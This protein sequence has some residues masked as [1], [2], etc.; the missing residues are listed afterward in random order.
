MQ[1]GVPAKDVFTCAYGETGEA[2]EG[3]AHGR[4]GAIPGPEREQLRL[5][6][7]A[8]LELLLLVRHGSAR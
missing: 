8:G 2:T 6:V 7:P 4:L 5:E 3:T 1:Y